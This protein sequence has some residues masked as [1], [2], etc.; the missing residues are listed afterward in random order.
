M[1][2]LQ[3]AF[4][5]G[6]ISRGVENNRNCYF[7]ICP[8]CN[9][10]LQIKHVRSINMPCNKCKDGY[11]QALEE[12]QILEALELMKQIE[13]PCACGFVIKRRVPKC[14]WRFR[15]P[16]CSKE[17]LVEWDTHSECWPSPETPLK[18]L[19]LFRHCSQLCSVSSIKFSQYGHIQCH[20]LIV[21]ISF[22]RSISDCF[23]LS[24]QFGQFI[25]AS[26]SICL[27]FRLCL[28][29]IHN[30]KYGFRAENL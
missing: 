19:F 20:S 3:K 11:T 7:R 4:N 15:C 25:I 29:L 18:G 17:H 30:Y 6:V 26:K 22:C 10:K 5:L 14:G 16:Q 24:V 27:G 9:R 2:D 21:A 8:T 1:T 13:L 12:R 28:S 23:C